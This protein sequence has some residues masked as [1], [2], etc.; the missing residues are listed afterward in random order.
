MGP[1]Q[2]LLSQAKLREGCNLAQGAIEHHREFTAGSGL[3]R[4]ER[5]RGGSQGDL[6]DG[7]L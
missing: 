7:V 5:G 2:V 1:L 3:I 4:G 6:R